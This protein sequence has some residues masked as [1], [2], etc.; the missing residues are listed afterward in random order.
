MAIKGTI[1]ASKALAGTLYDLYKDSSIIER[2][3]DE[4][5]KSTKAN[6]YKS[7]LILNDK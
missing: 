4:F 3:N 2:A 5:K 6:P 1:F 7:P